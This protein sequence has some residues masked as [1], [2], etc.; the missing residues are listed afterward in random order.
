MHLG[1]PPVILDVRSES[2]RKIDARKIPGAHSVDMAE[3][4]RKLAHVPEGAEIIV[5]CTC[6]DEASAARV[7]RLLMDKG[8]KRVRPLAGG[9]DA[10]FDAGYAGE[11]ESPATE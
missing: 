4:D 3:P 6:P 2:A 10:W 11:A 1:E 8:F 5:Y 9:L 7:A